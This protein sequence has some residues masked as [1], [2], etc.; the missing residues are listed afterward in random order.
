MLHCETNGKLDHQ[1]KSN[2]FIS[3]PPP[4][5]K[6]VAKSPPMDPVLFTFVHLKVW[7][8]VSWCD[9]CRIATVADLMPICR[10]SKSSRLKAWAKRVCP[11]TVT[12]TP[13]CASVNCC[14][15]LCSLVATGP[16]VCYKNSST[17]WKH[18]DIKDMTLIKFN[19]APTAK[20]ATALGPAVVKT[21][22][23]S[24]LL[25]SE[26]HANISVPRVKRCEDGTYQPP[27]KRRAR[28]WR[29]TESARAPAKLLQNSMLSDGSAK[30][31]TTGIVRPM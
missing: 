16:Q 12:L 9:F 28:I 4:K 7:K 11:W 1:T 13:T 14:Q 24:R 25:Y 17:N 18:Q 22:A 10:E 21:L 23:M 31:Y 27:R 30:A 26:R 29:E 8:Q 2:S 3:S 20:H 5:A 19:T 6:E 15:K